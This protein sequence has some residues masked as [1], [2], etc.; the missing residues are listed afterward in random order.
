VEGAPTTLTF[1]DGGAHEGVRARSLRIRTSPTS[2]LSPQFTYTF[3]ERVYSMDVKYPLLIVA[4]ADK[5]ITIFHLDNP[6]KPYRVRGGPLLRRSE[7]PHAPVCLSVGE[8]SA[9]LLGLLSPALRS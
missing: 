4:T 6:T 1:R 5:K 8:S 3:P 7:G 9:F 2:G